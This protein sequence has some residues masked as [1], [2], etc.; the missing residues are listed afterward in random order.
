M[1]TGEWVDNKKLPTKMQQSIQSEV[2]R[3]EKEKGPALLP[4]NEQRWVKRPTAV[5]G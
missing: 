2:K 4:A 1:A 5:E 3:K